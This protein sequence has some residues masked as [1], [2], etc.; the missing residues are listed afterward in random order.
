MY[1][2]GLTNFCHAVGLRAHGI[3]ARL[4][5]GEHCLLLFLMAVIIPFNLIF[6]IHFR[7]LGA[8]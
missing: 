7:D 8:G 6:F 3:V 4:A 2:V 1:R 5:E